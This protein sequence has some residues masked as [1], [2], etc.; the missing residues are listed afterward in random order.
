MDVAVVSLSAWR[1]WGVS[2]E[3]DLLSVFKSDVWPRGEPVDARCLS[4]GPY[5]YYPPG[6]PAETIAGHDAPQSDCMCGLY[7]W[8]DP[9]FIES[10]GWAHTERDGWRDDK[11]S[12]LVLG[13]VSVFGRVVPTTLGYRAQRMRPKALVRD[14]PHVGTGAQVTEVAARYGLPLVDWEEAIEWAA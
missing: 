6:F 4:A 12:H 10:E 11:V 1:V 8:L 9:R 14:H 7:A 5:Q 3:L 13:R 2:P